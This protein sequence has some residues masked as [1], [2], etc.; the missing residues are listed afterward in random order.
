MNDQSETTAN[1]TEPK[2]CK[3]GCGFFVSNRCW[4]SFF[5]NS[6]AFRGLRWAGLRVGMGCVATCWFAASLQ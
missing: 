4:C 3:M 2:L 1:A 5:E 6:V